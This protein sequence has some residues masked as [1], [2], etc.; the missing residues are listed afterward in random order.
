MIQLNKESFEERL[1]AILSSRER[2]AI[3]VDGGAQFEIRKAVF[4]A[5]GKQLD[6][7][8]FCKKLSGHRK[9]LRAY[10]CNAL[11]DQKR[12]LEAY[13]KSR[14]FMDRLEY[15]PYVETSRAWLMY[16]PSGGEPV[17]KGV[18]MRVAL[19]MLRLAYNNAYDVAILVTGDADLGKQVEYVYYSDAMKAEVLVRACD[20]E[21]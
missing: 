1:V 16:P 9:L 3:F 11:P 7:D 6:F 15:I 2:V 10:F 19:H 4:K 18:D 5:H 12:E 21:S 8:K 14:S 13:R 17:Q 20:K